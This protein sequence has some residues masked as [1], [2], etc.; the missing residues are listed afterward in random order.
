MI[1]AGGSLTSGRTGAG[2]RSSRAV[3]A[4]APDAPSVAAIAR[5]GSSIVFMTAP[6]RLARAAPATGRAGYCVPTLRH[7]KSRISGTITSSLSSRAKWPVSRRC[8]S[9]SGRSRR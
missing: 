2:P 9:A 8:N 5:N 4:S 3:C 1:R 7:R 6:L